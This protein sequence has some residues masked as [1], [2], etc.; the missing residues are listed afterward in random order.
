MKPVLLMDVDGVLNPYGALPRKFLKHGFVKHVIDFDGTGNDL[1]D[2]HLNQE[3]G[4]FLT[5]LSDHFDPYWCTFWNHKANTLLT[6]LLGIDFFPVFEL[7]TDE[8]SLAF[9]RTGYH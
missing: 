6:P 2:V 4:R 8:E 1:V 7:A 9:P 5:T 3:H